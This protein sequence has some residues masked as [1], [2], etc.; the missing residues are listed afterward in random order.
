VNVKIQ[1]GFFQ[2]TDFTM[3]IATQGLVFK[4]NGKGGKTIS[5]PASSIKSVTFYAMKHKME[6][7]TDVLID[8]YFSSESDWLNVMKAL[9]ERTGV[10]ITCEM[11]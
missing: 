2:R 1:T 11:N 6:I 3:V 8:A 4:P 5:I 9:Q 10:K 7:Q